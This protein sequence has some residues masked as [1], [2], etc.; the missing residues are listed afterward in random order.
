MKRRETISPDLT[1]LIDVVFL[2][3]I[4]FMVSTVFKSDEKAFNLTLPT[5]SA[6]NS[7]PQKNQIMI[8][9][10]SDGLAKDGQK[11]DFVTLE[12]ELMPVANKNQIVI[13]LRIDAKTAYEKV[14]KLTEMLSRKG[15]ENLAFVTE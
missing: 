2:L 9:L 4:F 7:A 14:A 15:F 5:T 10:T 12:N 3:L 8:E 6:Q 1:P 11:I 13:T